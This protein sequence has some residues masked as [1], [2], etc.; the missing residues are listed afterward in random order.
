MNPTDNSFAKSETIVGAIDPNDMIVFPKGAG[1]RGLVS[2]GQPL[3]YKIR[4]QNVG[5]YAARDVQVTS[6]IPKGT[7]ISSFEMLEASHEYRMV[8]KDRV[9][10]W[11]F[12]NINL[13]DSATNESESHGYILF[14]VKP[15][16]HVE[17][18][19][20]IRNKAEIVFDYEVP[21]TTNTVINT[22]YDNTVKGENNIKVF[23]NPAK[24]NLYVIPQGAF[25]INTVKMLD[26][27]GRE[28]PVLIT[29]D[30]T[31]LRVNWGAVEKGVYFIVLNCSDGVR[32]TTK[33]IVQ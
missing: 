26:G 14:T 10:R 32:R 15:E 29:S 33:V 22:I 16:N 8:V 11:E 1:T 7:D 9:I 17:P 5:T 12:N 28:V 18:G 23:P 3:Q 2:A 20:V 19:T 21:I 6:F 4:F 30:N 31:L 25:E 24:N 27:V 13:P